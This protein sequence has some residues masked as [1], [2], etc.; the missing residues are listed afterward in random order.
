MC[1]F[2]TAVIVLYALHRFLSWASMRVQGGY[3]AETGVYWINFEPRQR[4]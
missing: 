4:D 2:L 1:W 3:D